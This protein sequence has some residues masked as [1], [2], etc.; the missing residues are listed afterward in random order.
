MERVTLGGVEQ[1]IAVSRGASGAAAGTAVLFV[2]GGPGAAETPWISRF[3]APRTRQLALVSWDQRGAGK[4]WRSIEPR[5]EMTPARIERDAIELVELLADR[6]AG[7]V[8]LAGHSWGGAVA[9]AVARE[10]PRLVRALV[11]VAPLVVTEENDRLSWVRTLAEA[12]RRSLGRAVAELEEQGATPYTG[13]DL[14]ERYVVLLGWADRFAADAAGTTASRI[15]ALAA[16][17]SAPEWDVETRARYWKSYEESFS[18]LYPG[19]SSADLARDVKRLEVAVRVIL[20]RH[21]LNTPPE[22]ARRWFDGLDAPDKR[23]EVFERSG[24][25][26]HVEEPERF[27]EVLEGLIDAS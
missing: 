22:P 5:A 8:V 25:G 26:P 1:W 24:H 3:I 23:L 10:R 17:A 7:P 18:L 12:R 21:D 14:F 15:D 20:G 27:V 2:H 9:A 16:L 6:F 13:P 19:L 4:S 11:A